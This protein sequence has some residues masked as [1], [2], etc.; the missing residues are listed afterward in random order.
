MSV[1]R[2][3]AWDAL[4]APDP[5]PATFAADRLAALPDVARR[6]LVR[7]LAPGVSVSRVVLL[8]MEGEIKLRSWVP[9]RA[10]QVLRAGEGFV[11]EASAGRGPV[12]FRGG[13][14]LWRGHGSLDFRLWGIVPVARASG[15]DV[16]MSA[17]GRLA[18][19][20]VAWAP[21]ALLPAFG[22]RWR[23]QDNT[24]ATVA[25]PVGSDT[26]EVTVAIDADGLIES[27]VTRRWGDPDS[28]GMFTAIPFGG[29]V[30]EHADI[31]GIT[32][33]S[34]GRVGWWWGTDRQAEGEFFRYRVTDARFPVSS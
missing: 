6:A 21:Q 30:D 16:D 5:S 25:V 14:V 27:L 24:T 8:E 1:D 10:R 31:D 4:A 28:T 34:S 26:I 11:W 19:E 33:A 2:Q 23:R 13:D 22:T 7:A 17:A 3:A 15:P 12:R 32:I 29:A 18:A 9:F 20:T